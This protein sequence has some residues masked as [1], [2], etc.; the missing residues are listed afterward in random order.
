VRDELLYLRSA[1]RRLANAHGSERSLEAAALSVDHG[2]RRLDELLIGSV[3]AR[4][5]G[6]PLVMVP[7][8]EL[9][10]APWPILPS[11]VGIAVTISPSAT[12]WCRATRQADDGA[13]RHTVLIAG[14]RLPHAAS[15]IQTLARS[16][17]SAD[18]LVGPEATVEAVKAVLN[19]AGLAH[20]AAHGVFRSDNPLFSS[21][22]LADGRLAVYELEALERAPRTMV[23]SA[24][25]SGL[26][27][28]QPGDEIMGL[29]ATLFRL[30]TCTLL[31]S[32]IPVPDDATR[33]LMVAVHRELRP[34]LE[35]ALALARAQAQLDPTQHGMLA[36]RAG[37]VCFGSG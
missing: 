20:I 13:D 3:R 5:A 21:I 6:R 9:H 26:S 27:S 32:V 29:A 4:V 14:P 22:E 8:G 18:R 31:A 25:D 34:G 10:A 35:P 24:C 1:L 30:G 2:A 36:A 19:H 17:P 23:L 15:E 33:A 12:F 37:F 7:T 16:Y 28:V 11:L